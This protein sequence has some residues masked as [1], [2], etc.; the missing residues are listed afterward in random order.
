M[1]APLD[2]KAVLRHQRIHHLMRRRTSIKNITDNMQVVD[3]ALFYHFGQFDN[4]QIRTPIF[5]KTF[6]NFAVILLFVKAMLIFLQQLFHYIRKI[7]WQQL[8]HFRARI[9]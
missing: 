7:L 5:H 4:K 1:V 3:S 6:D 8:P 2:V 9:L